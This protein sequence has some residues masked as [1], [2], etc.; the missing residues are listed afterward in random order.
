[1]ACENS[2]E[3]DLRSYIGELETCPD[4][5]VRVK[6]TVK[7]DL[8]IPAV[9][10]KLRC[11][12]K[13]PA[14]FFENADG[15]SMPVV[16]NLFS[17][18]NKFALALN[19]TGKRLHETLRQ[20]IISRGTETVSSARVQ[21]RVLTGDRVDLDLLPVV[22]HND[23]DVGSYITGGITLLVDPETG[24]RNLG[25][26]RHLKAGRDKIGVKFADTSHAHH[27]YEKYIRAGYRSIPVAI[28]IG[29]HP[30]YYL[31]AV[32]LNDYDLD[33]YDPISS[34]LGS[35][36]RLVKCKT[37]DLEVPADAEIVL[38]GEINSDEVIDCGPIGEYTMVYGKKI[39]VPTIKV[40]AITMREN[41]VYLDINA[42]RLDHQLLGGAGRI[43]HLYS[44]IKNACPT[45]SDVY[46]PPSGCCRFSCYISIKKRFEGEAKNALAAAVG[47]YLR[48]T[49]L[50][51]AHGRNGRDW[52]RRFSPETIWQGLHELYCQ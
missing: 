44:A 37:V 30:V 7:T 39:T 41:P 12:G 9:I 15:Y 49:D 14:V 33:E 8:E 1:M 16:S 36:V 40:K 18:R 22:R 43:N 13:T 24:K 46:M 27:I 34:Y 45:V 48:D 10:E 25:I 31:S 52:A 47:N 26:Y 2:Y 19:T 38:E 20:P 11:Q 3:R 5:F 29:H 28:F 21:E 6:K 42:G 50:R 35:A 17:S 4:E 23:G 32:S 51:I